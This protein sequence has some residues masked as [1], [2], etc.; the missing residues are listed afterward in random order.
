MSHRQR[1]FRDWWWLLIPLILAGGVWL[2]PISGQVVLTPR[3]SAMLRPQMRIEPSAPQPAQETTLWVTDDIPWSHVLVTVDGESIDEPR[4][5]ANPGGT[6][7]WTWTFPFPEDGSAEL[8]FYHDCQRGCLERTRTTVGTAAPSAPSPQRVPT[9]LGVVFGNPERDWHGRS[10]WNVELTYARLAEDDHWGIDDLAARVH[11]AAEEGLRVLVRVDYDQAQSLPPEG[12]EIAL[13]EYLQYLQ[14]LARDQR[15][16]QVYAYSLGSGFNAQGMTPEW[17]ARVKNGYGQDPGHS[18]NAVQV[19]R[20]ED[21]QARV[22]V[23]PVQPWYGDQDGERAYEID[24]PWLNYFNT[25]VAALD[26]SARAKAEAG[27]PLAAPDGFA[28]QAPG[29]PEAPEMDGRDPAQ[30]PLYDLPRDA[31]DGAQAGFRVYRDWLAVLN[32]YP[33]TRGLPVYITAA[34][35]FAPDE[36]TPSA[37]NYPRGWLTTALAVIDEEPQVEALCWF[38]DYFPH[39]DQW[40]YFSLTRRPGRMIDAAEE[41]AGLLQGTEPD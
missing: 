35:T 30:E 14:R 31:W 39:D 11:R 28:V 15:L 5:E 33:S 2:L 6:W 26:E 23:G 4:W 37:Q 18:D 16:R 41:F 9:K 29:R 13:T 36:G 1:A 25:L 38:L 3:G 21:V 40:Q 24:V 32:T 12:D 19:M 34:N 27:I 10:G 8:I 20:T 22:L 7:T 17:V